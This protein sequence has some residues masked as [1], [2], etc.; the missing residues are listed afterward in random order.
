MK[1][2]LKGM[3]AF[4]CRIVFDVNRKLTYSNLIGELIYLRHQILENILIVQCLEEISILFTYACCA[5]LYQNNQWRHSE[6]QLQT[7]RCS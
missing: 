5:K 3:F 7:E 2:K 1:M 4:Y 6:I